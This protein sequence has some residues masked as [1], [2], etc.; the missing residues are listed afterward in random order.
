MVALVTDRPALGYV[1]PLGA[2]EVVGFQGFKPNPGIAE[3]QL[4]ATAGTQTIEV[5]LNDIQEGLDGRLGEGFPAPILKLTNLISQPLVVLLQLI[6]AA[7]DLPP[8]VLAV[9]KQL[10]NGADSGIQ[11]AV[12][13]S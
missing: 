10:D 11:F 9:I 8:L 13:I 7:A 1:V 4:F 3:N 6:E 12:V 2:F 5:P